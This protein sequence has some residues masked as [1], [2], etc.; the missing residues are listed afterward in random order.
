MENDCDWFHPL[1]CLWHQNEN[2]SELHYSTLIRRNFDY[3]SL[4]VL[5]FL[6]RGYDDDTVVWVSQQQMFIY[7]LY[8]YT[9]RVDRVERDI[10]STTVYSINHNCILF[11]ISSTSSCSVV[12]RFRFRNRGPPAFAAP[13]DAQPGTVARTRTQGPCNRCKS[14]AVAVSLG[15]F[16]APQIP[17]CVSCSRGEAVGDNVCVRSV[18]VCGECE[19][20]RVWGVWVCVWVGSVRVS[21]SVS[22]SA[23]VG[24]SVSVCG[25]RECECN[26]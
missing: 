22:V 5:L 11:R 17:P 26:C 19:C 1:L 21:V 24:V 4:S 3:K 6:E 15:D 13:L 7:R 20:A 10:N 18:S 8:G 16:S 23:S 12:S 14:R 9:C 25:E 2:S